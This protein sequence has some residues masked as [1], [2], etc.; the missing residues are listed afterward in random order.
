M[1]SPQRVADDLEIQVCQ[2]RANLAKPACRYCDLQILVLPALLPP[3]QVKGPA[4]RHAPGRRHVREPPGGFG[5]RP[6]QPD[7]IRDDRAAWRAAVRHL[8]CL[9]CTST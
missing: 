9:P 4:A 6:R 1:N 8:P 3:V 5:W 7:V 2:R